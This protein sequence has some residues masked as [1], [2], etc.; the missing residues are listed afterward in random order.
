M[1]GSFL[2][3][4]RQKHSSG[5]PG[6]IITNL[7]ARPVSPNYQLLNIAP[8]ELTACH[9]A[10]DIARALCRA[11]TWPPNAGWSDIAL[12]NIPS[13]ELVIMK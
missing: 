5:P 6:A 2:H 1:M 11:T 10:E 3:R 12:Q 9:Q 13:P 8:P 4:T 7:M